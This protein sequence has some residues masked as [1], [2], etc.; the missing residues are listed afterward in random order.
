MENCD[1][2]IVGG[3][4]AGSTCAWKLR[5]AGL[6]VTVLDSS[7]FPRDKVCGDGITTGAGVGSGRPSYACVAAGLLGGAGV[8][9]AATGWEAAGRKKEAPLLR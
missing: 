7:S 9:A 1:A 8:G 5:Q 2:L 4:P 6:D 3:G